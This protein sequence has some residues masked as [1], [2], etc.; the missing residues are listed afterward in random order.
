MLY[1]FL[2]INLPDSLPSIATVERVLQKHSKPVIEGSFRFQELKEFLVQNN[3]PLKVTISED[4]TRVQEKFLYD[5]AT[6]NIIGPVLP[7]FE[8]GIPITGSFPATSAAAI[9]THLKHGKVASTG[10]AIMAQPLRQGSPAFCLALF[11]T[12]NRFCAEQVY[13]RWTFVKQELAKLDITVES[14]SSDGDPKLLCAVQSLL[15][16]PLGT[17]FKAEWKNWYFANSVPEFTVVQDAIHT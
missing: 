1:E 10:Y 11:G 9:C 14:F 7:L 6:N 4:G 13:K 2:A 12:D 16:N 3:F 8:N 5:R 17:T 15:F